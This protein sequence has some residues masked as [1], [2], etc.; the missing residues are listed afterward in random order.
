MKLSDPVGKLPGVGET[1]AKRLAKLKISS[2]YQLLHHYPDHYQD[3]SQITKIGIA[4]PQ[5]TVTIQG[6]IIKITNQY[7]GRGKSLQKAT[8]ADETGQIQ[9]TWFNQPFLLNSFKEGSLISISG[10]I[11]TFGALKTMTSPSFEIIFPGRP[12]IHTG[13][14][15]A[16]YPETRGVSSKWLRSRI[17]A[18]LRL[19]LEEFLPKSLLTKEGFL[20][21]QEALKK[22]HFPQKKA[23]FLAA[24][25]RLAFDE[26]F[27][28]QVKAQIKKLS[29]QKQRLAPVITGKKD[30]IERLIAKLPFKLTQAQEK[31]IQKT[32]RAMTKNT[33]MNQLLCGDV[34]SGK[35][36][37]AIMAAFAAWQNQLKTLVMA[38]TEILAK[39]HYDTFTRFLPS[40]IRVGLQTGTYKKNH[41]QADILI[42]THAL[43]FRKKLPKA[44][45]LVV[46]DEQHRFG[47]KQRSNLI[48]T[49]GS[50]FPHVLTMTATPIPRSVALVLHG[51]LD[52]SFLD[53]MPENRKT[54]KTWLVPEKK[55]SSAYTWIKEQ[56]K[57]K[58]AQ[59]FIIYPLIEESEHETMKD[60]R[61]AVVE[62]EK[63]TK[64]VFADFRVALI[65][66]RIKADK[67]NRIIKDFSQKKIDILVATSVVE[68]GL[69][70]PGATIMVIEGANRFGLA[71]IHQL[72]G[73]IGRNDRQSYCLLFAPTS[74]GVK[75]YRRLKILERTNLGVELAKLDLEERGPGEIFGTTQHGFPEFKL[76]SLADYQLVEK[77]KT[78]AKQLA[79]KGKLPNGLK[80]RLEEDKIG[81]IEP[82]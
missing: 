7:R 67:K 75:S 69:D 20:P 25:K 66:G 32:F 72:R 51:N 53:Q 6:K 37:I 60:I 3:F 21:Y 35:T 28:P 76:A 13:Q 78:W 33:A 41:N 1:Y 18:A 82:N 79:G 65:H 36:I 10:V 50:L 43:L 19:P 17:R 12:T 27:L 58:G 77:T 57:K 68:V 29:W 49:D 4:R 39:Q 59:V 2:I 16:V 73:R 14:I 11:D 5:E 62:Y 45:G 15:V 46:I 64:T 47:V 26:L 23:D 61:A 30:E 8:V 55:R 38:P 24:R 34:G 31:I 44:V 22:I 63:L 52:L 74:L 9:I 80:K 70:I 81:Q 48:K 42:G 54:V 56:I 71:Q 40:K